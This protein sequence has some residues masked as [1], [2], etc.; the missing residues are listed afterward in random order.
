M[1]T[2]WSVTAYVATPTPREYE[3]SLLPL[4]SFVFN[5]FVFFINRCHAP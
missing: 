2:C 3:I 4:L 5:A 1:A